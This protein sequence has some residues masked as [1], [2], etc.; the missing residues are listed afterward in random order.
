MGFPLSI[1]GWLK[2]AFTHDHPSFLTSF[3]TYF[4]ITKLLT[5]L[6]DDVAPAVTK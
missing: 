4:A 3:V 6:S 1:S 2:I 5:K